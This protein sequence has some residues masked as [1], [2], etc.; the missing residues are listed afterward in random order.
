MY[1]LY[2]IK[3][4][5]SSLVFLSQTIMALLPIFSIQFSF[6][7]HLSQ[8]LP[9]MPQP[10]VHARHSLKRSTTALSVLDSNDDVYAYT[11]AYFPPRR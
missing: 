2:H 10:T 8:K 4:C 7:G 11:A 9:D 6:A 1:H 5:H 3:E